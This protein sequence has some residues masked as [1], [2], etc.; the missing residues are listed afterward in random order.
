MI[1]YLLA[2]MNM[3]RIINLLV[4]IYTLVREDARHGIKGFDKLKESLNKVNNHRNII[5]HG[6]H[7]TPPFIGKDPGSVTIN[8]KKASRGK[9]HTLLKHMTED[10]DQNTKYMVQISGGMIE[11]INLMDQQHSI[12]AELDKL[13]AIDVPEI[14]SVVTPENA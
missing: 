13:N 14:G 7:L 4:P 11:I 8:I 12:S 5:I 6:L 3:S 2:D 1:A 9:S 10:I